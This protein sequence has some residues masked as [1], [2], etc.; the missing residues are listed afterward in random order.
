MPSEHLAFLICK[1]LIITYLENTL[2]LGLKGKGSLLCANR[3]RSEVTLMW[4]GC[5][6]RQARR[7]TRQHAYVRRQARRQTRFQNL[8]CLIGCI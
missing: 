5:V 8:G 1:M 7:Q 2:L 6:R 4:E 3:T